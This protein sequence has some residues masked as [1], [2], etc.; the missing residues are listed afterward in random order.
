MIELSRTTTIKMME[1]GLL[2]EHK[3]SF[4]EL[5][6]GSLLGKGQFGVVNKA[7]H[8]PSKL[9]FAIKVRKWSALKHIQ[10]NSP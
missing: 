3:I 5:E 8:P 7:Y 10:N 2:R 6:L 9:T 4:D 1:D